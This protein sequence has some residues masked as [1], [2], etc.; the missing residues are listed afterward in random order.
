[1]IVIQSRQGV[2]S[3]MWKHYVS[4]MASQWES[5]VISIEKYVWEISAMSNSAVL[6]CIC[7]ILSAP[8]GSKGV[9]EKM[10]GDIEV[11]VQERDVI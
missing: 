5:Q 1:M 8:F 3:H 11:G 9:S 10:R 4:V 2:I 6:F 7:R